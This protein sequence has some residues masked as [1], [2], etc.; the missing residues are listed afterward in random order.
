MY[1]TNYARFDIA[2]VTEILRKFTSNFSIKHWNEIRCLR[3][4]KHIM[5]YG[6]HYSCTTHVRM[7]W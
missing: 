6:L 2:C 3:Y 5:D 7:L 4:L 1:A